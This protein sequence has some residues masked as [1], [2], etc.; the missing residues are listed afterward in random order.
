MSIFAQIIARK[1]PCDIVFES[2]R[3]IAIRD[4]HPIAP[5]HLLIIPKKEYC[6]LQSIPVDEMDIVSHIAHVA[7]LLALKFGIAEGYR[8]ITNQGSTAGQ[9]I[10]HL[11]FHLIGGREL[12]IMG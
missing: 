9:N 4:L 12:G 10:F 1:V 6:D 5:V 2:D 3:A 7:Q 8:F 11:H